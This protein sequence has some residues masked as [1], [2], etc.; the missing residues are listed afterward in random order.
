MRPEPENFIARLAALVLVILELVVAAGLRHSAWRRWQRVDWLDY[1][2]PPQNLLFD[3]LGSRRK[4][5]QS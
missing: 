4:V 5:G 3:A 2:P 1:K